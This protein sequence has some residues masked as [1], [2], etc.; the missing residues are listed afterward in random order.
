MDTF[1][2]SILPI[3]AHIYTQAYFSR[4]GPGVRVRCGQGIPCC[5]GTRHS[6]PSYD[7]CIRFTSGGR[8]FG[9]SG[10]KAMN[11]VTKSLPV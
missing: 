6:Y 2:T 1:G 11:L 4:G 8:S 7:S 3:V 9:L 5:Y 10:R